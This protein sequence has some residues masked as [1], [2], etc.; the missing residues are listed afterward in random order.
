VACKKVKPFLGMYER[1]GFGF[2]SEIGFCVDFEY[3]NW[4]F[5]VEGVGFAGDWVVVDCFRGWHC[6]QYEV[7]F[8]WFPASVACKKV[9]PFLGMS[10]RFEIWLRVSLRILVDFEFWFTLCCRGCWVLS[11]NA[12]LSICFPGLLCAQM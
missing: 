11:E 8:V 1:L 3:S 4:S 6:A 10:E 2:R 12:W 7:T 5:V 9:T